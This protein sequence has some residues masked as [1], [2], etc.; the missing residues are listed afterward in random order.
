MTRIGKG[1]ALALG[2]AA[3]TGWLAAATAPA[4]ADVEISDRD[5]ERARDAC[6]DIAHNRDWRVED[7]H[8]IRKDEDRRRV[9]IEVE[10]RRR[11]EGAR[12][13]ECRYDIRSGDA[14]FDDQY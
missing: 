13:R 5:V 9:V 4:R 1:A 14:E 2:I 3:G 6:R 11:G 8:L 7:T 10:G 12:Q